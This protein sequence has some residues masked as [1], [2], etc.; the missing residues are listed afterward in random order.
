MRR[1]PPPCGRHSSWSSP[2]C[3]WASVPAGPSGASPGGSARAARVPSSSSARPPR[4]RAWWR[5]RG[6]PW[7][8]RTKRRELDLALD[9]AD[10]VTRE[11]TVLKGGGGALLREKLVIESAA[12]CVIV[13]EA[14]KLVDAPGRGLAPARRGRPLR[15]GGHAR[16]PSRPA[17]RCRAAPRARRLALRHRRGPLPPGLRAPGRS[18]P[19]GLAA[20][21]KAVTGVVEHG[22]FLEHARGGAP[23]RPRRHARAVGQVVN[24][25]G[26]ASRCAARS[27][28]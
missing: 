1:G 5:P 2:A 10:E 8:R 25:T 26:C 6:F 24:C 9:G 28:P 12:R 14:R 21:V 15:L 11:L 22:L 4:L 17:R 18:R 20:A 27:F 13:A 16:T 23:G 7:P 3:A 19:D